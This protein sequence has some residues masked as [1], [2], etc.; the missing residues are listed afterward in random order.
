MKDVLFKDLN[1][2]KQIA[3]GEVYAPDLVDAHGDF[4]TAEEIEKMA[5]GFM[6]SMNLDQVDVGHDNE[7]YGCHVVESFIARKEDNIFIEGAWVVAIH[8]PD[9]ELW[10]KLK[11]GEISGFSMESLAVKKDSTI[12]FN[13]PVSLTGSTEKSEDG[14][15]HKYTVF[16]DEDGNFA[17]GTTSIVNGHKHDIL[18]GTTTE[19]SADHIHKYCFV[20]VI[21][22]LED[23]GEE[24]D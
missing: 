8:I 15:V 17:G 19:E 3:M 23:N 10:G 6:K 1:S 9:V 4:M 18:S 5:Y 20:D 2:E 16:I 21:L 14:H 7:L 11:S 12:E 24:E 13:C 22:E